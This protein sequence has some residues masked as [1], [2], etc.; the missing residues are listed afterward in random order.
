MSKDF[1]QYYYR[2]A[3]KA[4]KIREEHTIYLDKNYRSVYVS[5]INNV[6]L[7]DSLFHFPPRANYNSV[8]SPCS[9]ICLL[10]QIEPLRKGSKLHWEGYLL[11]TIM[12]LIVGTG[13]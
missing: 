12:L 11:I 3:F 9:S 13:A 5:N 1:N 10:R 6:Q 7:F 2:Q 4:I 8:C